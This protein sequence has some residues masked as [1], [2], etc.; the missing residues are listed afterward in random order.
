M[1]CGGI[2]F[3]DY[4]TINIGF[5]R[6]YVI[7]QNCLNGFCSFSQWLPPVVCRRA[8]VLFTLFVFVCV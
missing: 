6:N 4:E 7:D 1:V 3:I 8:Y 2:L 5:Y